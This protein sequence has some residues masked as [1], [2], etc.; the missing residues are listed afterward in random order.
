[1]VISLKRGLIHLDK[2]SINISLTA[3]VS[4]Q[5]VSVVGVSVTVLSGLGLRIKIADA[6]SV[7]IESAGIE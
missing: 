6:G 5:P 7:A 4:R 1:M 3:I 2:K